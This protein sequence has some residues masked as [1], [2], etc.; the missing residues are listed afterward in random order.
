MIRLKFY[1][2]LSEQLK[3]KIFKI[4]LF[5]FFSI[6]VLK[7]T[8]F[9]HDQPILNIQNFNNFLFLL[10]FSFIILRLKYFLE[11]LRRVNIRNLLLTISSILFS[12]LIFAPS[13]FFLV[14]IIKI[15]IIFSITLSISKDFPKC[16]EII[17]D[18]ISLTVLLCIFLSNFLS[19]DELIHHE[20]WVK[21]G[22]GFININIPSLF[23]FSS[24]F[25]YFLIKNRS[26]F[27]IVSII[28]FLFYFF[29]KIHSRTATFSIIFLILGMFIKTKT[30]HK[31]I[32]YL[33]WIISTLYLILFFSFKS[34]ND[35]I[36]K[37][38]FYNY[39]DNI[40][41]DRI[42]SLL[43]QDWQINS[44]DTI[45]N[46]RNDFTPVIDSLYLELIRYLGLISIFFLALFFLNRYYF[47]S[48]IYNPL[49]AVN[50]L[51]ISGVFEGF[52][53][54]ITPMILFLTHIILENFLLKNTLSKE[55]KII[56]E[57]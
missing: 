43:S 19:P 13:N 32:K 48:Y 23:L 36:G 45:I 31:A 18:S 21:N 57:N 1:E 25:G 39:L 16:I 4:I 56:N 55:R 37:S 24:I 29:L 44:Y 14:D 6:Y 49:F 27:L 28:N 30:F 38:I 35:L 53:Y 40:L 26:K 46:L 9:F 42:S 20:N 22:G 10:N 47:N 33:S 51:L 11:I 52:F 41:S 54:K 3:D 12:L 17:S 5:I 50:I 15:F 8:T 34:F 2:N 7:Q